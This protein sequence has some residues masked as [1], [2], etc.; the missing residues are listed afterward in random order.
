MASMV[1]HLRDRARECRNADSGWNLHGRPGAL[2][3]SRAR[4]DR[5]AGAPPE[6]WTVSH[7]VDPDTGIPDS[8]GTGDARVNPCLLIAI[9][10]HGATIRRV[11]ES[12]ASARLPLV[13]VNDA[14]NLATQEAL[15]GIAKDFDWVE[16]HHHAA[17]RGKGA[18]LVTGYRA[19]A[20][21][22]FTHVI[23]LDADAQHEAADVRRFLA[24]ARADPD[25]LVIGQ[26]IF[27]ADAPKLR[28]YGRKLS[29]GLVWL[30]TLSRRV[31]DPLCGFRCV[32]LA[33]ALGLLDRVSMGR[34]MDFEPELAVRLVWMG[35]R[36]V[37]LSTRVRYFPDGISHFDVVWDNLRLAWLYARLTL[38]ML[39]RAPALLHG[40]TMALRD[41]SAW[42][43]IA[44]RG[45]ISALLLIRWFYRRFG[46]RASVALLTPIVAYFFVTAR[47]ARRASMDYLRTLWAFPGGQAAL[48]EAPRWRHVFRHLHEFAENILDRMIAWSGDAD[49]IHID[50]QATEHLLDLIREG[51]GGILLGSHLGSYDMLRMLSE[52]TGIVLNVLMFTQHSARINAFF[53]RLC[54]GLQMRLIHFEPGS[55]NAVFEMKA[56]ID[57][58][59][60]VGI[61][62][63]RVWESERDRWLC[64]P[65][66]GRRARFPVGALL[67]QGVLGCPVFLIACVRTGPGRYA[68]S[69]Q[70]FVPA[71]AVSRCD[72][73]KHAEELAQRYASALE[74]WCLSSPYQWFNFFDFWPDDAGPSVSR[75]R[76]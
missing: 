63:D 59:E 51:R 58:G 3:D 42:M 44:E 76:R 38:G 15:D 55:V 1:N 13:I 73:A 26:P 43:G 7:P 70:P 45:S 66:L 22:G 64:L 21:R 2:H 52:R 17:N 41:R 32:P 69:A 68:A 19:A 31:S 37:N 10:D 11:V 24:A 20:A 36:V 74:E 67:L 47:T 12:V 61:L 72:R 23:Q 57:R 5:A 18:A 49:S 75:D 27:D 16:I 60:F 65:F 6:D 8:T 30:A 25:A 46:R 29:V 56:A 50:D 35:V 33:P 14:S 53:E 4:D 62:G 40:R 39:A 34:R 54:P 71:G 9:Y 28:L 48:G